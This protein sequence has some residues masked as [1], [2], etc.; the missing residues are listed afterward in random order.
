MSTP[1][2]SELNSIRQGI[3]SRSNLD[4]PLAASEDQELKLLCARALDLVGEVLVGERIGQEVSNAEK[5]GTPQD[6]VALIGI[7]TRTMESSEWARIADP[8][9]E[10]YLERLVSRALWKGKDVRRLLLMLAGAFA[11]VLSFATYGVVNIFDRVAGAGDVAASV[12]AKLIEAE[13]ILADADMRNSDVGR[14]IAAFDSEFGKL[15]S[16]VSALGRDLASLREEGEGRLRSFDEYTD[17]LQKNLDKGYADATNAFNTAPS[18]VDSL[19]RD[20]SEPIKKKLDSLTAEVDGPLAQSRSDVDKRL[21]AL[22]VR[23]DNLTL[24]VDSAFESLDRR[25]REYK[26]GE[27][28]GD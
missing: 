7:A 27:T 1:I 4:K 20:Q 16:A 15:D 26:I 6:V 11:I 13:Q 23:I 22:T 19:A 21:A 14:R 18:R 8:S 17:T 28:N 9:E 2:Y 10:P 12:N 5:D 25:Q 3:Q 24:A